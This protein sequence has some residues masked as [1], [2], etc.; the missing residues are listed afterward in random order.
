MSPVLKKTPK[1]I[2]EKEVQETRKIGKKRKIKV[3]NIRV[4]P[5]RSTE[6]DPVI[7][8]KEQIR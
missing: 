8:A 3:R 7:E 5:L 6:F 2:D 4:N 1:K